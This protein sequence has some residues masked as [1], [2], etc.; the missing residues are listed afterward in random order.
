MQLGSCLVH[1]VAK[2]IT[3]KTEFKLY[4]KYIYIYIYM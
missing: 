1:P 2:N 4:C 3:V